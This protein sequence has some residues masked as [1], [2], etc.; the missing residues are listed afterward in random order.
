MLVIG[1]SGLAACAGS[2][3]Y[4]SDLRIDP[5]PASLTLPCDEAILLSEKALTQAQVERLWLGDRKRLAEC[6]G[7][8][9]GLVEWVDELTGIVR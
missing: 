5:P 7:R 2:T 4:V 9:Q 6:R 1:L 8:H 3:P